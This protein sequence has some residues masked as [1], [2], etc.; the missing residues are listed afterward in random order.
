MVLLSRAI[1][2]VLSW[3]VFSWV[4][5][6]LYSLNSMAGGGNSVFAGV[7]VTN[8]SAMCHAIVWVCTCLIAGTV[9]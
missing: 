2:G 9:G 4:G 7:L 6:L 8:D 5:V 1:K 3:D